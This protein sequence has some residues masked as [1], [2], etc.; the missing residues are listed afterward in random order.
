MELSDINLI[1]VG[2]GA[3]AVFGLGFI[4]YAPP[5]F[6][7]IWQRHIETP[8]TPD[9]NVLA[10]FGPAF[11]L[12]CVIGLVMAAFK[13]EEISGWSD[14][15][16]MG[17]ILG[18]GLVATSLGINYLFARRSMTLFLIDAGYL[19]LTLTI[20]GALIAAL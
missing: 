12:I 7:R 6:G 3:V 8:P 5:V 20:F 16:L 14:G 1:A 2:I 18:L 4:W 19:V 15:A 9:T 11:I 17:S 13:P 10:M